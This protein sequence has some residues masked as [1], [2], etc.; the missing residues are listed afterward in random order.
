MSHLTAEYCREVAALSENTIL[1][2]DGKILASLPYLD[3][4]HVRSQADLI[5]RA[6]A[7]NAIIDLNFSVPASTIKDWLQKHDVLKYLT[8]HEAELLRRSAADITDQKKINLAWSL[9]ALW[10]LMWAGQL[11]D[12]LDFTSPIPDSMYEMCPHIR[13]AEGSEKFAAMQLRSFDELYRSLDLHYRLHWYAFEYNLREESGTFDCSRF[14]E[15]RRA[16]E[17]LLN[18]DTAWDEIMLNT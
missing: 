10:A 14:I 17:W 7:L 4:S 2:Y 15:R 8:S 3:R 9:D 6:L 11:F 18:P 16:L 13:D 12:D 1:Q 5:G